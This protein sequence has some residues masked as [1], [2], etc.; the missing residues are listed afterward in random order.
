MFQSIELEPTLHDETKEVTIALPWQNGSGGVKSVFAMICAGA[1]G[2]K[3]HVAHWQRQQGTSNVEPG[4]PMVPDGT[5]VSKRGR[6]SGVQ[7]KPGVHSLILSY[8]APLGGSVV[9]EAAR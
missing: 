2:M 7:A 9:I 4:I 5:V 1:E 8:T 6:T 3:I